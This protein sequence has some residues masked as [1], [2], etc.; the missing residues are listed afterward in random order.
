MVV[1]GLFTQQGRDL[2]AKARELVP[3][4][5]DLIPA[6]KERATSPEQH[7]ACDNT[8]KWVMELSLQFRLLGGS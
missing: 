5:D 7:I 2:M 3:E 6:L 1:K 8:C 4:F